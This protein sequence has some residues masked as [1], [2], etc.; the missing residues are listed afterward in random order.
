VIPTVSNRRFNALFLS[1]QKRENEPIV[2]TLVV[3][4]GEYQPGKRLSMSV[5]QSS[6]R[7]AFGRVLE[8]HPD[9]VWATV[10][11]VEAAPRAAAAAT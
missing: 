11:S 3:P 6:R 4:P 1:M 5:G 8:Q 2:Q 9:W 7:I 10:E